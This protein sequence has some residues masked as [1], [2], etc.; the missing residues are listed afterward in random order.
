MDNG[1]WLELVGEVKF[2]G[3]LL[4]VLFGYGVGNMI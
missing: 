3:V 4:C 2:R 1:G